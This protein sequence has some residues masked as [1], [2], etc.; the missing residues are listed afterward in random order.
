MLH[1]VVVKRAKAL[2]HLGRDRS[3][4]EARQ[5]GT[6]VRTVFRTPRRQCRYVRT[7]QT[8]HTSATVSRVR[9]VRNSIQPIKNEWWG[10]GM[11]ICLQQG[12]KWFALCSSWCDCHHVISCFIKIQIGLTF[13]VPAYPD[14]PGKEAVKL[15]SVCLW[16]IM[17]CTFCLLCKTRS[18]VL[19]CINLVS[20]KLT[21]TG[22][23]VL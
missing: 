1:T 9:S 6:Y 10:T 13:L 18:C 19:L 15:V 8:H 22:W 7:V 20:I 2:Q 3:A 21:Y 14:C 17:Y 4:L 11:P 12:A 16:I 23:V 5:F